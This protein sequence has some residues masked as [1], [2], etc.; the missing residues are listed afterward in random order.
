MRQI[1]FVGGGRLL[2]GSLLAGDYGTYQDHEYIIRTIVS[3]LSAPTI[4][5]ACKHTLYMWV[6]LLQTVHKI[7]LSFSKH[8]CDH[9]AKAMLRPLE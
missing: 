1:Y 6:F 5:S 7:A 3:M 2:E 8:I 4:Y 9:V